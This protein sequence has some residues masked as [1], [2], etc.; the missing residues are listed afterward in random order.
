MAKPKNKKNAFTLLWQALCAEIGTMKHCRK[1]TC[2]ERALKAA[3]ELRNEGA[4]FGYLL[5]AESLDVAV[6]RVLIRMSGLDSFSGFIFALTAGAFS[7]PNFASWYDSKPRRGHGHGHG[8]VG[9]NGHVN[10]ARRHDGHDHG[11]H[12]HGPHHGGGH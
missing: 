9:P 5:G 6:E 1:C 12:D 2:A 10:G 7:D 4:L 8:E 3:K 11:G